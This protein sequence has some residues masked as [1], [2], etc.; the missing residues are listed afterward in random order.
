M[1]DVLLCTASILNLCAISIDRYFIIMHS[2]VYTQR[3]NAK[4]MLLMILIVWVVS[5]LISIPPLFG[6]GKPSSR[7]QNGGNICMVSQDLKYQLFATFLAFYLP[8]IIM[9][10]IY[11]N[12]YRAAEKIKLK[13][14]ETNGQLH[15]NNQTIAA[16]NSSNDQ[17]NNASNFTG[18]NTKSSIP[19]LILT[20]SDHING[21]QLK[22]PNSRNSVFSNISRRVTQVFTNFKRPSDSFGSKNQKA[23]KALGVI[24]GCFILCW[25]P[26]FTLALVKPLIKETNSTLDQY[27]PKWLDSF[28]L[29]LGYFNSSLNPM[30]YA[31]FNREFRRP[32]IEI[33]CFRCKDINERLRDL[34]RRRVQ[35]D[36]HSAIKHKNSRKRS[37]I[38]STS[39]LI[40]NN[41]SNGISTKLKTE[42]VKIELKEPPIST[43]PDHPDSL[44]K[45]VFVQKV[46]VIYDF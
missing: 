20:D 8:L 28:L 31:R 2:L 12:I 30:I 39:L 16:F 26:F 1:A 34:D 19:I 41:I 40:K 22:S 35:I 38:V 15:Y 25:L 36:M 3:R 7:L 18:S 6:W 9:I 4:L 17:L 5:A 46:R 23:T 13:E 14:S 44:S 11:F 10:I 45:V 37:S 32:F 43:D 29:W 27:I 21:G 24:M 33:I 42:S